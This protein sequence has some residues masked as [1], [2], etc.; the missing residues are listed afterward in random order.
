MHW[1]RDANVAKRYIRATLPYD[2]ALLVR[3]ATRVRREHPDSKEIVL[4]DQAILEHLLR[5]HICLLD[6]E[7]T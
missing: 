4:L 1:L 7:I 5:L 3:S 2:S 6:Q